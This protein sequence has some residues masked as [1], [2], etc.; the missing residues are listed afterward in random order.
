MGVKGQ[1]PIDTWCEKPDINIVEH[2]RYSQATGSEQ[3]QEV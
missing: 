1:F 3:T 2:G